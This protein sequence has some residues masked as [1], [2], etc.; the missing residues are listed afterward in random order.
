MTSIFRHRKVFIGRYLTQNVLFLAFLQEFSK[1]SLI[2]NNIGDRGAQ[3]LA[4]LI[5]NNTVVVV[6]I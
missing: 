5:R 4:L 2:S 6:I 3:F 1:I